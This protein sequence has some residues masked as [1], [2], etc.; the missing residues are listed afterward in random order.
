MRPRTPRWCLAAL[1]AT[2]CTPS[3]PSS[4]PSNVEAP[5]VASVEPATD[6]RAQMI[7]RPWLRQRATLSLRGSEARVAFDSESG[8]ADVRCPEELAG[9][10][11]QGC[12][13]AAEARALE[14]RVDRAH[15]EWRGEAT[16]TRGSL[17]LS[18]RSPQGTASLHLSCRW[19]EGGALGCDEVSGWPV[20]EGFVAPAAVTFSRS[21]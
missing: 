19:V 14:Q 2:G 6:G 17:R 8:V 3:P 18:L 13:S 20:R 4:N 10:S 15:D 11:T 12:G 5:L 21:R 9:T 1:A 7:G 16:S